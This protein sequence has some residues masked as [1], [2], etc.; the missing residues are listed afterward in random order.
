M[1]LFHIL[2]EQCLIAPLATCSAS[3]GR[4]PLVIGGTMSET[5]TGGQR[6]NGTRAFR[7]E[8]RRHQLPGAPREQSQKGAS[9]SVGRRPLRGRVSR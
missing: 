4:R 6:A 8:R 7:E 5:R 3:V 1:R 2:I 9:A